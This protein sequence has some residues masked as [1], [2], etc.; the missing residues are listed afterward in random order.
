M[1]CLLNIVGLFIQPF[2]T[3]ANRSAQ[4][5]RL[6]LWVC[7]NAVCLAV[8]MLG[9]IPALRWFL[10][11][12]TQQGP[13]SISQYHFYT[14]A[15]IPCHIQSPWNISFQV[16]R[17]KTFR[18]VHERLQG[19]GPFRA[20]GIHFSSKEHIALSSEITVSTMIG[21]SLRKHVANE[22]SRHIR[23]DGKLQTDTLIS[24]DSAQ[25]KCA[26]RECSS[27]SIFAHIYSSFHPTCCASTF[28]SHFSFLLFCL[29]FLHPFRTFFMS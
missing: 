1:H 27:A 3:L 20:S 29:K 17:A 16:C 18:D 21:L 14:A 26:M 9:I 10:T 12:L 22:H 6:T 4:L 8:Q 2:A 7:I 19:N 25:A 24:W 11:M 28:L 23:T 15:M 13:G 5:P